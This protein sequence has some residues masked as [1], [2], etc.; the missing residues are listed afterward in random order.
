[1]NLYENLQTFQLGAIW[2]VLERATA[3]AP[4][5]TRL[6]RPT[7]ETFSDRQL[8]LTLGSKRVANAFMCQPSV[9]DE[10]EVDYDMPCD[11]A[12]FTNDYPWHTQ[13]RLLNGKLNVFP[14]HHMVCEDFLHPVLF[15]AVREECRDISKFQPRFKN[16][17]LETNKYRSSWNL[18]NEVLSKTH[19]NTPARLLFQSLTDTTLL[20]AFKTI[21]KE[22]IAR[23]HGEVPSTH[24]CHLEI[25]DDRSGYALLPHCDVHQK[26]ITCLIYLADEGQNPALGTSLYGAIQHPPQTRGDFV[27]METVPYRPNTA[28]IFAPGDNTWHGVEEVSGDETRR[29]IQFQI[30]LP[31]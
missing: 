30:N 31:A 5:P 9:I 27:C 19:K 29:A 7:P 20:Y 15:E 26:L 8:I 16:P 6:F 21:F 22:Q 13:Y 17:T 23:R 24:S 18:T 12:R 1:M 25:I 3:A 10:Q 14:F 28:L 4:H 2:P 11:L